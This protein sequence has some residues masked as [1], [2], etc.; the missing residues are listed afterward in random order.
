MEP[1]VHPSE[2]K[3]W[4]R[5]LQARRLH[6]ETSR[7]R[8][9]D[10]YRAALD[11]EIQL[12]LFAENGAILVARLRCKSADR[13]VWSEV[14]CP[15]LTADEEELEN[16]LRDFRAKHLDGKVKS[17]GVILHLADE[18]AI[19]ELKPF[20]EPPE[21]LGSIRD[22][23][24]VIPKEVLEDQSVSVDDLSFRLFPYAGP[25]SATYPGAAITISRQHERFLHALRQFGEQ[26]KLPVRTAALSAP[27][28][29]L[30]T[31]PHMVKTAPDRPFCV[32]FSYLDFSV[33]GFFTSD[34]NLLMLRSVR[35]HAGRVPVNVDVIIQT[36]AVALELPDPAVIVLPLS[37][38][39]DAE[40]PR[41][42]NAVIFDWSHHS[43][44][45]GDLPLEFQGATAGKPE[46]GAHE[47]LGGS[48][49]FQ[50]LEVNSWTLQDFLPP[51]REEQ[52]L[53]PGQ[54]E[55]KLMRY[56]GLAIKA[57]AVLILLFFLWSGFRVVQIMSHPAW[58]AE[59]N[60]AVAG[61][62]EDLTTKIQRY[63]KWSAF[64]ADR[65]KGWVTMELYSR[66][67]PDTKSIVIKDANYVVRPDAMRDKATVSIEREWV[68]NGFANDNAIARLTEINSR[69]GLNKVFQ[70]VMT[71]TGDDSMNPAVPT[72]NLSV[73]LLVSENK[74]YSPER[75]TTTES[76][77][78]ILFSL[79][80]SQRISA[81]DPLAIPTTAAP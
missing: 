44:F 22:Q 65:S 15:P 81:E 74:R 10:W 57:V 75:G 60:G 49:T 1:L 63:E 36:M 29:A 37:Q 53:Y 14:D 35:H 41:L 73:N 64:L 66:L 43:G 69:E 28:V 19:S 30:G 39:K 38:N 62:M 9:L 46:P 31:L 32:L 25:S 26:I 50:D 48:Q 33:L 23:L 17:L 58:H 5:F 4:P 80:I 34:G 78:P 77:F 18:F 51:T 72:R 79:T 70:E 54:V 42:P 55:M 45:D 2:L 20:V 76:R 52:D 61:N 68:I 59:A 24:E 16:Y 40:T 13:V 6:R 27:L 12:H 7:S 3:T 8:N 71:I 11:L 47:G 67:F 56:G 21:D